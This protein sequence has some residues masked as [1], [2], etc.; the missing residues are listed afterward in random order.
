MAFSMAAGIKISTFKDQNSSKDILVAFGYSAKFC[1]F[2]SIFS[3]LHNLGPFHYIWHD[4][5]VQ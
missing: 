1:G 3:Y 4:Y 2:L 5:E